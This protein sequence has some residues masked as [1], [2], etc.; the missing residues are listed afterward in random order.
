MTIT[1]DNP[2]KEG[3]QIDVF[4]A[5]EMAAKNAELDT[6]KEEVEKY[7]RV[8]AEKTEHFKKLNDLTEEEK[9][10]F[11]ARD[12][13]N[14]ARNEANEKKIQDLTDQISGDAQK[15]L[16]RDTAAALAKYHG[17]DEKLKAALEANFNMINMEGNDTATIEERARLA[18]SME[19]GKNNESH[20]PLTAA[21]RGGGSP[22]P[23]NNGDKPFTD[24]DK[25]KAAMSQ[26]GIKEEEK[27]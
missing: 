8:S 5:E 6:T 24:T 9:K 22:A 23:R 12:L 15:R 4:T 13:E 26:M 1:I 19:I 11:T 20:A 10:Q 16:D 2:D 3:E 27:K 14:M 17:G 18:A 21:M 25:G 7:K